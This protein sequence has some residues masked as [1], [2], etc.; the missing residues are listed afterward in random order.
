MV[1]R[2]QAGR[3]DERYLGGS[4]RPLERPLLQL[5]GRRHG[6]KTITKGVGAPFGLTISE[7]L[8]VS[9]RATL[10]APPPRGTAFAIARPLLLSGAIAL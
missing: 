1:D 5:S 10:S 3:G 4:R 9:T 6:E 2:W 8:T 7:A